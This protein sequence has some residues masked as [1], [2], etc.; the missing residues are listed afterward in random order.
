MCILKTRY[1]GHRNPRLHTDE[2][3]MALTISALT[4]PLAELAQQQLPKLRGCDAH[5]TVVLSEVDAKLLKK[6]GIRVS[7]QP[8]YETKKLYHK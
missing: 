3:L 8:K 1:L 4:N 5:F 2:V 7:C 6:L